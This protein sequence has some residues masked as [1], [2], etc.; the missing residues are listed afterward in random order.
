MDSRQ[1]F[2]VLSRKVSDIRTFGEI[3]RE[4]E[5]LSDDQLANLLLRQQQEV[6]PLERVLVRQ[7]VMSAERL[8]DF[9]VE[10]RRRSFAFGNRLGQPE[11]MGAEHG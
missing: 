11:A 3:A 8:A 1:V 4:S 6:Q 9:V 2:D 5:Y 7:Q 10:A